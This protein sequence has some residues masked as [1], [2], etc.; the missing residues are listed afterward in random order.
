VTVG[1]L[2]LVHLQGGLGNQLFQYA[3][4]LAVA[5]ETGA[6]VRC[7]RS[8]SAGIA[9]DAVLPAGTVVFAEP[10]DRRRFHLSQPSDSIAV[11]LANRAAR[12]APGYRRKHSLLVQGWSTGNSANQPRRDEPIRPYCYL[13][14]WFIHRSWFA[15]VLSDLAAPLCDQLRQHPAFALAQGATVV[16][17]RR[18]DY[19]R[20][21]FDLGLDYYERAI[22]HLG[23]STGPCWVVS[24]DAAF[25]QLAA[26]WLTARGLSAAPAPAFAGSRALADLALTAGATRVVMSNSTFCWWAVVAGDTAGTPRQVIVPYPWIQM[27]EEAAHAPDGWISDGDLYQPNWQRLDSGSSSGPH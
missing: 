22:A 16:S 17:F 21:G 24:D 2:V 6:P 14:G 25:G 23:A 19:V 7:I 27:G 1:G 20:F 10:G 15:P 11:R 12:Q 5:R 9:I 18:G 4:G 13:T 3:A 26:E 8:D